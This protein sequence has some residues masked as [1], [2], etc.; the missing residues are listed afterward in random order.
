[1]GNIGE[2]QEEYEFEPLTIPTETPVP[3]EV[4][5][6]EPEKVPA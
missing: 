3:K 1:M 4:P 5:V 6:E 2:G